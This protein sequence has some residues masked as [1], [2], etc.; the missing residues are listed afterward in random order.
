MSSSVVEGGQYNSEGIT[1]VAQRRT[2]R[3]LTKYEIAAAVALRAR[4]ITSGQFTYGRVLADNTDLSA[5]EQ[6]KLSGERDK[7]RRVAS[8]DDDEN[9]NDDEEEDDNGG[10]MHRVTNDDSDGAREGKKQQQTR[11]FV[12]TNPMAAIADQARAKSMP[13]I[14]SDPVMIAKHELVQKRLPF[15]V[16]RCLGADLP[17]ANPSAAGNP[18]KYTVEV[19]PIK[20]LELDVRSI[21]LGDWTY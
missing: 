10:G 7:K 14:F 12:Q 17:S 13:M 20:D 5:A 8:S 1:P 4:D 3:F 6:R 18:G 21:D 16:K 2:S 9:N 11:G 19:I 15:I